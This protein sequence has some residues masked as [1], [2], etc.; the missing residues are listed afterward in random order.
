MK[1]I[2][3]NEAP[4]PIGPYS[5]AIRVGNWLFLSGQI[6]LTSQGELIV[7]DIKKETYQVLSNIQAILEEAG[8]SFREV[9][10][11]GIFLTSIKDFPAVNEIYQKF[12]SP[13]YPSRFVVEVSSLP[14]GVH[15]EIEC[16]AYKEG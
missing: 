6:P 9:I 16:I 3:S 10:R 7:G 2:F 8:F 13:P 4:R 14:K 1:E 15:I 5:Q 12:F 11:V